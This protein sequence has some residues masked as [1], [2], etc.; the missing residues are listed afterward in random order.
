MGAGPRVCNRIREEAGWG[1]ISPGL[2]SQAE[3]SDLM[4]EI[5]GSCMGSW[6]SNQPGSHHHSMSQVCARGCKD[7]NKQPQS[8]CFLKIFA[9]NLF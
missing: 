7:A 5:M 2:W 3:L 4:S 9:D 8:L 1:P 6:A